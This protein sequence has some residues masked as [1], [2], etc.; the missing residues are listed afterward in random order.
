MLRGRRQ[1]QGRPS[2]LRPLIALSLSLGLFSLISLLALS[3]PRGLFIYAGLL[4]ALAF[5]IVG[6]NLATT[7]GQLLFNPEE[8]EVLLH[9]P[10]E[11]R[12]LLSAK[13]QTIG[14]FSLAM[15]VAINCAGLVIGVLD[16]TAGWRFLPAHLLSLALEV[17]FTTGSIVLAYNLCLRWFGRERLDNFMTGVQVLLAV[18][19]MGAG[20]IVPR[21]LRGLDLAHL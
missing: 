15:A 5:L 7:G 12:S 6:M 21:M 19:I 10:I 8:A 4:H 1:R 3:F 14:F 13:L 18:G 9:R 11:P 16:T 17:L 2:R 20:Q